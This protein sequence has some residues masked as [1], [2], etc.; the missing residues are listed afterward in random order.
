M[1]QM[2]NRQYFLASRPA[3]MPTADN[4]QC[5]DVPLAPPGPGEVTL[6]NL[7]ISLDPAIRGWMGDAPNYIEP[8]ALGDAVRSSVIGRVVSSNSPD[9]AVGD[10]GH[11][12]GRLGAVHD[13]TR[14][15]LN[16]LDEAAVFPQPVPRRP[17]P[18]RAHRLF[19]SVGGRPS[20]RR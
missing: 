6:R 3:Q 9:F 14:G 16:K 2:T 11:E 18:H 17:G 10:V 12:R 7:Y 20:P 19:R 8:I 13:R 4:V 5:R 15:G 1:T